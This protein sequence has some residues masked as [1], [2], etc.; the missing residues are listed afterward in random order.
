MRRELDSGRAEVQE[1]M[2]IRPGRPGAPRRRAR[3]EGRPW[4]V[5]ALTLLLV[6][7]GLGLVVLGVFSVDHDAGLLQILINDPFYATLPPLGL[8]ALATA[9]GFLRLRPGAWV[10][11][12][13]VQGLTLLVALIFY[14]RYRPQGGIVYGMMIYAIIMVLYLNYAEVPAV[15]RAHPA[16]EEPV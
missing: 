14:V 10:M 9:F 15:F 13:L 16:E 7:Q 5:K 6:V 1:Q 4:P 2:A 12:M 11:A 3:R 8:L